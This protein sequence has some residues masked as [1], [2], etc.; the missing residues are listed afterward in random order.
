MTNYDIVL[1][2]PKEEMA[3]FMMNKVTCDECECCIYHDIRAKYG[4]CSAIQE[5]LD[6][7]RPDDWTCIDGH[8]QWLNKESDVRDLQVFAVCK[9]NVIIGKYNGMTDEERSKWQIV[10]EEIGDKKY[11]V[12]LKEI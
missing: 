3:W 4:D 9:H 1:Q 10:Y 8:E 7:E 11:A 5:D 12:A 2:L 6:T